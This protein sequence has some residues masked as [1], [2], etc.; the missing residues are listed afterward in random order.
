[1]IV[2][3]TLALLV[4]IPAAMAYPWQSTTDRWLLG[5][6]IGVIIVVFAW[7]RGHFVSTTVARRV[8]MWRRR[9]RGPGHARGSHHTAEFTTVTVR[10]AGRTDEELPVDLIVGYLDRYGIS[11]DKVRVTNRDA[12]GARTTWLSLTLGAADNIAAL[13]ARSTRIPLQDTADLAVRRLS[14]HLR[15]MGWAVEGPTGVAATGEPVAAAPAKETW[16]GIADE[17]GY[18]ATYRIA[19]DDRL[20]ETLQA[21]WSAESVETWTALEFSGSRAH[22]ELVAACALRTAERPAAAPQAG[23]T[24]QNGLHGLVVN[25][26][27]PTSDHRLPGRP[28][29]VPV[30]LRAQLR[31]PLGT[32]LS[33]T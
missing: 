10:L 18:L 24:A 13:S 33:R 15:E 26:L 22:P 30:H 1:M 21:L 12:C 11:F 16:R 14:D 6:A 8:A 32:A 4:G 2:R 27:S 31:W 25:A 20:P 23:M 9:R 3:L 17:R 7:W 5:V 19:V 29:A 28:V